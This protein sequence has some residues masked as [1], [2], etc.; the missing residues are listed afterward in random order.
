MSS[1][2]SKPLS[3]LPERYAVGAELRVVSDILPLIGC[4]EAMAPD[5]IPY[6]SGDCLV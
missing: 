4:A 1:L 6:G 5:Q 3:A 2:W